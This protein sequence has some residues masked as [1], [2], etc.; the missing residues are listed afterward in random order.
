MYSNDYI[1]IDV[2]SR[3]GSDKTNVVVFI[4]RNASQTGIVSNVEYDC[5]YYKY[6][7]GRKRMQYAPNRV[8]QY[9]LFVSVLSCSWPRQ[10][11]SSQA[12]RRRRRRRIGGG[13][14]SANFILATRRRH[15]KR[16][17]SQTPMRFRRRRANADDAH[18][19]PS[20]VDDTSQL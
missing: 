20:E 9:L 19:I 14:L 4:R 7:F 16:S 10:Q 13:G 8:E 6:N 1:L 3:A 15:F 18:D 5:V 12:L 2:R 17:C 11:R